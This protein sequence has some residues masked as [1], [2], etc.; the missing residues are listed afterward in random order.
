M[1]AGMLKPTISVLVLRHVV[2]C[3]DLVGCD[4]EPLL[5]RFSL[6]RDD[7]DNA[8]GVMPLEQFLSVLESAAQEAGN[9]YLGLQAGRLG[10]L[11]SLGALGFLFLSAPSLRTAFTSFSANLAT[12]QDAVRNRFSASEG[13]ATYE[14]LITDQT[15]QSRRQD[16]EFSIAIMHNMC[17]NYVGGEFELVEV[18]FEHSCQSE[19]RVYREFFRCPVFFD[20]ETNSITFEARFLDCT[21]PVIDPELYPIVEEHVRRQAAEATRR[22]TS[23]GA[24]VRA[25]EA[26]PLDSAPQ[27][28]DVAESMGVSAATLSRRLR[29][30]G[31]RWR[32]LVN[33]RRMQAAARLLRQSRRDVAEIALSVGFAE[34]ASFIRRFGR[35]F[36]MTPQAYRRAGEDSVSAG[37]TPPTRH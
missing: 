26:S 16:A 17:R 9:P 37:Q 5:A 22:G 4:P 1:G 10:A 18:R 33:E 30:Q 36:G 8:R 28:E 25:L 34:S 15:L 24:L 19:E 32:D 27:L 14:Y 21:S 31:L 7:L 6:R 2:N 12:I 3:L 13:L 35:H 11:N 23:L 20:Q 29:A